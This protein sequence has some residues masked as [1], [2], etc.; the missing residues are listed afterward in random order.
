MSEAEAGVSSEPA[1]RAVERTRDAWGML[2]GT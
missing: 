2:T 1:V